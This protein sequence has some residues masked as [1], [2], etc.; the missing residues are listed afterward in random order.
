M[1]T[2]GWARVKKFYFVWAIISLLI[3]YFVVKSDSERYLLLVVII[4][5]LND[6]FIDL[7]FLK[8]IHSKLHKKFCKKAPWP[9][10]CEHAP[11]VGLI[12][13][14]GFLG[15]LDISGLTLSIAFIDTIIDVANDMGK[16]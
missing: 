9:D 13:I 6:L 2:K 14:G 10:W 12:T 3:L 5:L 16:I 7:G 8:V 1:R 11:F 15:I 4:L